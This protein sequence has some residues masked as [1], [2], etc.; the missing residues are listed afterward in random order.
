MVREVELHIV[1]GKIESRSRVKNII[2]GFTSRTE[3]H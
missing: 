3:E 1:E 2:K